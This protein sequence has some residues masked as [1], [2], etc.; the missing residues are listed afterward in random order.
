M[1]AFGLTQACKSSNLDKSNSESN[2]TRLTVFQN[3]KIV[4]VNKVSETIEIDRA[5]FSLRFYNKKYD[6]KNKKFHSAQIAAFLEKSDFDNINTGMAKNDLSCFELGSGMA[7]NQS[8]KYESLIFNTNG[9]HYTTY[10]NTDSKRLNLL[11]ESNGLIKLE[12]EI[13]ALYYDHK[14]LKM[15]E[16]KLKEFYIAF[17]IDKNLNGIIDEGELNK[18]TVKLK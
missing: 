10:E 11:K 16:T 2:T 8:G 15:S 18:L 9:H 1:L 7:P 5:P 12:F 6:S 14:D 17:L 3:G 4:K 13:N